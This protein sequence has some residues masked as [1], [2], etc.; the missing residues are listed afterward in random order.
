MCVCVSLFSLSVALSSPCQSFRYSVLLSIYHSLSLG[1]YSYLPSAPVLSFSQSVHIYHSFFHCNN[2]L[3]CPHLFPSHSL[4][5]AIRCF[6]IYLP[7][8]NIYLSIYLSKFA[9]IE[10]D[11]HSRHVAVIEMTARSVFFFKPPRKLIFIE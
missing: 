11:F 8:N 1:V 2:S 4:S 7:I 3:V 5:H 6:L 10:A 9:F